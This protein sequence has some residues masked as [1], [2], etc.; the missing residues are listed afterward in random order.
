M[1]KIK[2]IIQQYGPPRMFI[3]KYNCAYSKI[4]KK[5]WWDN[6]KCGGPIVE[7]GTHF[8]DIA[9]YIMG[10]VD[11]NTVHARSIYAT[12]PL[13]KLSGQSPN[14]PLFEETIPPERRIARTTV[15]DFRF[16]SG[17]L[18]S[19]THGLLLHGER[20]ESEIEIWGDGYR[21]VWVDPTRKNILNYRTTETEETKEV[22][23][24]KEG[25]D[26]YFEENKAF[27]EAIVNGN[28]KTVRSKY[29]DAMDTYRLTLE[30]R[31]SAENNK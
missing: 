11:L 25:E 5:E 30:I 9:L 29:Y 3:G 16:K 2:E 20:Y 4:S 28:D 17:A 21:C 14:V 15:S 10:E 12:D 31:T 27:L 19:F 24:D 8:C 1:R 23:F 18:G 7:Q 13:G 6:E 26:V 22:L